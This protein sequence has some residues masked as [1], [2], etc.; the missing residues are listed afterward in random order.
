[1]EKQKPKPKITQPRVGTALPVGAGF[2]NNIRIGFAIP[3]KLF[4][5]IEVIKIDKRD[6]QQ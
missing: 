4:R 6:T 2:R 3:S 5:P 1:M